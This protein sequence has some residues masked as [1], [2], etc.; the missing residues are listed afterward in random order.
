MPPGAGVPDPLPFG[1]VGIGLLGISMMRGMDGVEGVV[2][3]T[4][5]SSVQG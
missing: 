4:L 2:T 5:A 1:M 3:V